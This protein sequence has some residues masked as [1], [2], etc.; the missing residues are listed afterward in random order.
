MGNIPKWISRL[1]LPTKAFMCLF[2]S[3]FCTIRPDLFIVRLN[4][5][6][7]KEKYYTLLISL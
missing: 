5:Y 6:L 2:I 4:S 3:L 7:D 1:A